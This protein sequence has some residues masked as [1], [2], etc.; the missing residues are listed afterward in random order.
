MLF[1]KSKKKKDQIKAEQERLENERMWAFYREIWAERPHRS[2]LSGKFLGNELKSTFVD[3]LL[4]KNS[5]PEL[6]Y[7]R[8]NVIL[9]TP[10]E[11]ELKTNGFPLP[12]HK[13]LI[14]M[15]RI[16]FTN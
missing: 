1:W 7:E 3:H 8:N 4:E 11:H 2:E 16:V 5:H 12:K 9:L 13:E 14:K 15:A 6:K 10:A